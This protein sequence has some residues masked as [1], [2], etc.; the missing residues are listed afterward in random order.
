MTEVVKMSKADMLARRV[1]RFSDMKPSP[2]GFVDTRIPEHFRDTFNVIGAGVTED[3]SL[4]PGIEEAEDFNVTYIGAEP[5]KGAALHAHP[6][7]EVFVPLTGKWTIYFNEGEAQEEIEL[8]PMDCI[9]VPPGV[10][11][12][13]RNAGDEYAYLF[14]VLGGTNSGKVS[15]AR[16]VL[17]RSAATGLRLDSEGNIISD[18]AE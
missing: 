17:D 16:E 15:W 6:T 8:G 1:A 13:F 11:R 18:A 14:V 7:V 5:G 4:K 9:S 12:G 3:S 10:M 2:Q